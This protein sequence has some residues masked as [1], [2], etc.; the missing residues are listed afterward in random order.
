FGR[1]WLT[2]GLDDNEIRVAAMQRLHCSATIH[3]FAIVLFV[4]SCC[5]GFPHALGAEAAAPAIRAET[6]RGEQ[7]LDLAKLF[8]AVVDTVE[9]RFFD[10][11]R[12]R[13]VDW[14]AHAA[15]IRPSVLSAAST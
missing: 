11:T 8:D 2:I 6:H 4:A 13:E 1:H 9:Q 7:S 12:L 10:V 3:A 5:V 14:Q 15:A